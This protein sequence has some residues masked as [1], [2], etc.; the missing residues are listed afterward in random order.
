[1]I[2]KEVLCF[3]PLINKEEFVQWKHFICL[4]FLIILAQELVNLPSPVRVFLLRQLLLEYRCRYSRQRLQSCT[5]PSC[6]S[7][8]RR[9]LKSGNKDIQMLNGPRF[10]SICSLLG[11]PLFL[12]GWNSVYT[13]QTLKCL[14]LATNFRSQPQQLELET[15]QMQEIIA[16]S[17]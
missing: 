8:A 2:F 15:D 6:Y 5:L 13:A 16:V 12:L 17:Q 9:A 4:F 10:T 1:M 7:L 14:V 3:P 11:W